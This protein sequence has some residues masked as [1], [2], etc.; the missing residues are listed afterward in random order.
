MENK[1]INVVARDEQF[2]KVCKKYTLWHKIDY[3]GFFASLASVILFIISAGCAVFDF[4]D[5]D[6]VM[7]AF[8]A[9]AVM[10]LVTFWLTWVTNNRLIKYGAELISWL[11]LH[12]EL[13]DG[14]TGDGTY[15]INVKAKKPAK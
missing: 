13:L 9:S 3:H 4:G 10:V 2:Y 8:G 12:P 7:R 11:S 14:Y 15:D 5:V 1:Q 6:V